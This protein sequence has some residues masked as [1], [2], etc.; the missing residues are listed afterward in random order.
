MPRGECAVFARAL[1][2]E[3]CLRLNA[4]RR[5]RGIRSRLEAGERRFVS[6][7]QSRRIFDRGALMQAISGYPG[8]SLRPPKGGRPPKLVHR[9]LERVDARHHW[10]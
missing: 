10:W 4:S 8:W 7:R 1:R 6:Y 9:A 2:Q 3:V 5:M